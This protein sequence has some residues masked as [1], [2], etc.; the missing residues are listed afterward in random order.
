MYGDM[1]GYMMDCVVRRRAAGACDGGAPVRR[2]VPVA[3]TYLIRLIRLVLC[4]LTTRLEIGVTALL[5]L[6]RRDEGE[7]ESRRGWGVG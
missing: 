6:V 7:S 1:M 4:I 2:A 5:V 3:K